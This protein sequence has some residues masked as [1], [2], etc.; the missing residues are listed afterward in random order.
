MD[1]VGCGSRPKATPGKVF[2]IHQSKH[3]TS[4][5]GAKVE[6]SSG[7]VI[8]IPAVSLSRDFVELPVAATPEGCWFEMSTEL[9]EESP[10]PLGILGVVGD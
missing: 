5:A 6:G 3:V 4:W 10:G 2:S 9:R 8:H 7:S 1:A